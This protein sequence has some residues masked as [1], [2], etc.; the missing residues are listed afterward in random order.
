MSSGAF[1]V[2]QPDVIAGSEK[3]SET[4]GV[5][6]SDTQLRLARAVAD[7]R[8]IGLSEY[9]RSL[10]EIDL[11]RERARYAALHSIFGAGDE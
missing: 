8:G 4:I 11:E 3:L 9:I 2:R 6:L 7:T 1:F 5:K 10:V